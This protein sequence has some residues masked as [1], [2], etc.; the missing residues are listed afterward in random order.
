MRMSRAK[1]LCLLLCLFFGATKV[2]AVTYFSSVTF[3]R[4][5]NGQPEEQTTLINLTPNE[6]VEHY[7][8]LEYNLDPNDNIAGVANFL[9]SKGT[10]L[11]FGVINDQC[12]GKKFITL[13]V[14]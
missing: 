6:K 7:F 3:T 10:V 11:S 13:S 2:K 12:Q 5:I 1:I 14:S 9:S 4:S 8:K